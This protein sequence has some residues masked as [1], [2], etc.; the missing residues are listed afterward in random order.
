MGRTAR[1]VKGIELA[2]PDDAVIGMVVMNSSDTEATV[3]AV[4]ENGFGKRTSVEEYRLQHRG[5]KG[6]ITIKTTRRNGPMCS[7]KAVKDA[8]ELMV[9]TRRGVVIRMAVSNISTMGRNTQGVKI[10]NLD[11]DDA[12]ATIAPIVTSSD[13]DDP[14][15]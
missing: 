9:I 15:E 13:L 7:I 4:S 8:D 14:A 1:G 10:I 3:L 12:V 6:I 11:S 2:S 5:G